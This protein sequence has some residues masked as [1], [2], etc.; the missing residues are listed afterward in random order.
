MTGNIL[1][2]T[3]YTLTIEP[4]V[5][6][7]FDSDK[8]IQVDGELIARGTETEEINFTSNQSSPAP[9]DWG[10]ILFSD[11]STDANYD[12]NEVYTD[13]SILEYCVVEYAGGADVSE[14]GALRLDSAHPFINHC[15]IRNNSSSGIK[16]WDLSSI[17]KITNN[18]IYNNTES[19]GGGIYA[20]GGTVEITGNT[21]SNN[22]AS[23]KGGGIY[24]RYSNLTISDNTISDNT[25]SGY[26][27]ADG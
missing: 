10:Y 13:G 26:D 17:L 4:G 19:S 18:N 5:T 3:G 21:I 24:T 1:V 16:A 27:Y 22:T 14:N 15:T 7:K 23:I 20:S 12:E 25:S 11:T 9:G 8:C 6:I 2:N